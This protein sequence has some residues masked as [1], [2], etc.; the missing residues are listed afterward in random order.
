MENCKVFCNTL[1]SKYVFLYFL[2]AED[3]PIYLKL[4]PPSPLMKNVFMI[5][6]WRKTVVARVVRNTS[7][8]I[9]KHCI[10][11]LY[12][13]QSNITARFRAGK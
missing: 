13:Y 7:V 3:F 2:M 9:H 10:N 4:I 8:D 6:D 12:A 1:T 5:L 11:I